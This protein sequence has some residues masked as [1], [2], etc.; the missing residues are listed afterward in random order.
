V[1]GLMGSVR[2]EVL[3]LDEAALRSVPPSARMG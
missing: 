3:V 1:L 2:V